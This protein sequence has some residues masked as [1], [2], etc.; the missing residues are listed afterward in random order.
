MN[1]TSAHGTSRTT[2][3]LQFT[4]E[5]F[6][7]VQGV[8]MRAYTV[9]AATLFGCTGCVWNTE[10][11]ALPPGVPSG[12]RR[13]TSAS[14]KG[15][16]VGDA[17]AVASMQRWLNGTWRPDGVA[18]T[19]PLAT[20][21]GAPPKRATRVALYPS[22]ARIDHAELS[23]PTTRELDEAGTSPFSSFSLKK[24]ILSSGTQW[25]DRPAR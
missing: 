18:P 20:K 25:A 4:F 6:G 22:R 7:L 10:N 12:E 9:R 11:K 2:T 15:E 5:V 24:V 21:R 16:V 3:L 23:V 14:V 1:S 17:A 19:A 13:R 8:Y